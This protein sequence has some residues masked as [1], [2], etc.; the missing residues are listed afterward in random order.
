MFSFQG[1]NLLPAIR[2]WTRYFIRNVSEAERISGTWAQTSVPPCNWNRQMFEMWRALS[3]FWSMKGSRQQIG[4]PEYQMKKNGR[5][6]VSPL[7]SCVC[8][9][10]FGFKIIRYNARIF[11]SCETCLCYITVLFCDIPV[12]L[13]HSVLQQGH[14]GYRAHLASFLVGTGVPS[15]RDKGG[16]SWS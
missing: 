13:R 2:S 12:G 15:S 6:A 14:K 7:L 9:L 5:P 3:A 10:T 16:G 1:G 8:L 4:R 11:C